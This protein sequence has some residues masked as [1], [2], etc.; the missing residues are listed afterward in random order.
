MTFRKI[1]VLLLVLCL[2]SGLGG[3]GIKQAGENTSSLWVVT[4]ASCSDGMNLQAEMIAERMEKE[5]PGLTVQLDILPTDPQE[6]EIR[7]RACRDEIRS[8][9]IFR[10]M[11]GD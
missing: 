2:L 5:N 4:E 1:T 8:R 11:W 6:R 3:C 9:R 7:R 10:H